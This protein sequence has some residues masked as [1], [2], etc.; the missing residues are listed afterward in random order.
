LGNKEAEIENRIRE[1]EESLKSLKLKKSELEEKLKNYA[2]VRDLDEVKGEY[3]MVKRD[4]E[5]KSKKLGETRRELEH[6][7]ERLKRKEELLKE[8][9]D[10]EKKLE[11]YRVISNDFR[12]DRFQKYVSEIMLRK[13]VDRASE[14]FYKFTGNYFFE[15]ERMARGREK[16]IVVV[17]ISTSQKRPVSSLSGGETFLAS[18]SFAFAVSDLLSG[19]ANLES[20]FIDE[21]FGSLDQDMRERVSEILETIKTNVNKMIGIVSHIPDFAERFTERIVVEKKGDY[22]EVKVIY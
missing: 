16:D 4:L 22:S 14:Y 13:V 3:G 21:G 6:L 8:I 15:L 18:L 12:G 17:D 10:L 9:S 2:D 5:E 7:G 20:L 19:S 11:I 1:F